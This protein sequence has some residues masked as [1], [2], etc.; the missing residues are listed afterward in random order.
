MIVGTLGSKELGVKITT[1][2]DLTQ[3]DNRHIETAKHALSKVES[4][5]S[6]R[7]VYLTD[8]PK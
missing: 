5:S 1:Y 4:F 2:P 3:E 6:Y 7:L 8:S